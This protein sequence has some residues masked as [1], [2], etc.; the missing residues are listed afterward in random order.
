MS[1][2]VNKQVEY[3]NE[4]IAKSPVGSSLRNVQPLE[5]PS[6]SYQVVLATWLEFFLLNRRQH[7][8]ESDIVALHEKARNLLRLLNEVMPERTGSTLPDGTLLGWNLWKA[9]VVLHQAMERMMYGYS[10]ITSAQGSESAHKVKSR[11]I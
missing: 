10:E 11:L 4:M 7:L 6:A 9:H 2:Y 5:D 3:I 1:I 8:C